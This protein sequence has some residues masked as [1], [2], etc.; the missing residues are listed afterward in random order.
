MSSAAS[1]LHNVLER[2]M[3]TG[4]GGVTKGWEAALGAEF[5]SVEFDKRFAE[6]L[7]LFRQVLDDLDALPVKA[8]ER[9]STW[10]HPWWQAMIQPQH[11][12]KNVPANS[13]LAGEHLHLLAS[14]GDLTDAALHDALQPSEVHLDAIRT[15]CEAWIESLDADE[16]GIQRSVAV[17]LKTQFQHIIW[18][19]DN[20]DLFGADRVAAASEQALGRMALINHA[21]PE[22]KRHAWRQKVAAFVGA[23]MFFTGAV[24][25]SALAI[26]TASDAVV[27]AVTSVSDAARAIQAEVA[28]DSDQPQAPKELPPSQPSE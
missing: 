10:V 24:Q 16:F 3:A 19:L 28:G 26:D 4:S 9:F 6:C 13:I 18:L 12:W 17:Q 5:G 14:L 8:R 15:Q 7:A 2:V 21:I 20:V 11:A 23:I 1:S 22:N 25:T 27:E